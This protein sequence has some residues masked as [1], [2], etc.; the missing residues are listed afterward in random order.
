MNTK[1]FKFELK[2]SSDETGTFEGILSVYNVVDLG[3]DMVL[4]GAFTKTIKE[5]AGVVP[6]LW[7]H[8]SDEPIGQLELSDSPEGLMVKGNI[9]LEVAR[10]REAYTLLKRGVI[11]G[12]SIG[13]EAVKKNTEKG[14]RM[15]KEVRLWEGSVV[16]FPMLPAAQV[17]TVKSMV[18]GK[19]FVS[20]MAAAETYARRYMM[21]EALCTALARCAWSS[22]ETAEEMMQ[23]S[24]DSI[25]QFKA[26]YMAF[27]PAWCDLMGMKA[28]L[29]DAAKD[30]IVPTAADVE[31]FTEIISK[32]QALMARKADTS[33]EEAVP[34]PNP[35]AASPVGTEPDFHSMLKSYRQKLAEAV[36]A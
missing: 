2:A 32:F 10:G 26:A 29:F 15:L 22:D 24:S 14:I 36:A 13:Y 9:A 19:D 28:K 18:E 16:T 5:N 33:I 1:D 7:Q 31:Q 17:T 27:L 4:P 11:K 30:G 35:G 20:E 12:L 23:E 8:K 3:N 6:M 25:D 34:D 21:V